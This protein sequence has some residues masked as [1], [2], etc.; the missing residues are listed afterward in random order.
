ML[1]DPDMSLVL[2]GRECELSSCLGLDDTGQVRAVGI[3]S[4]VLVI[5]LCV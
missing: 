2:R 3:G 5:R 4:P 1:C